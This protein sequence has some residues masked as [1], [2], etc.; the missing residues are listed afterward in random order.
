MSRLAVKAQHQPS[1]R[2][3]T[4]VTLPESLLQDARDLKVNVSQ[5]CEHGLA[6]EVAKTK[7][8]VWLK[9]NRPAMD[10]WNDYVEKNGLPL[11]AFRQF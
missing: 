5:A 8:R 1:P 3:P 10:A 7:L 6:A 2:R 9:E 4:N 11:D